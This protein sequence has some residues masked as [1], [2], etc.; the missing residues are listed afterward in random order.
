MP[1]SLR[2]SFRSSGE[3]IFRPLA[4]VCDGVEGQ[5]LL[6]E[7][8][9]PLVHFTWPWLRPAS[10]WCARTGMLI[11]LMTLRHARPSL[12]P[13]AEAFFAAPSQ[14]S[15]CLSRRRRT[16]AQ[17]RPGGATCEPA[18][19]YIRSYAY[20]T[21]SIGRAGGSAR[22]MLRFP[23]RNRL[24]VSAARYQRRPACS[25][26]DFATSSGRPD[27]EAACIS[28]DTALPFFPRLGPAFEACEACVRRRDAS[29]RFFTA[30]FSSNAAYIYAVD[31]V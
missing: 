21:R 28:A 26:Q 25:H 3:S 7:L 9:L 12:S 19:P 20:V 11:R 24:P 27:A 2:S 22:W 1:S 23:H 10:Y 13:I 14:S 15:S 6:L 17:T 18:L 29:T 5:L 8:P 4:I 31:T 16:G 30:R